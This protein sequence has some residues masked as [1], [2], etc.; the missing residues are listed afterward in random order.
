MNALNKQVVES[1]IAGIGGT[2]INWSSQDGLDTASFLV[3]VSHD[4]FNHGGSF[5][6]MFKGTGVETRDVVFEK[7]HHIRITVR[8]IP[9]RKLLDDVEDMVD[10]HSVRGLLDAMSEVCVDKATHIQEAWQ[11]DETAKTWDAVAGKLHSLAT[12]MVI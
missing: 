7:P 5:S 8:E 4:I 1:Q 9:G 10:C 2:D 12:K 6:L 3:D 11:D